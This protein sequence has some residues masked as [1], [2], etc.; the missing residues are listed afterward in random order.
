MGSGETG[1]QGDK[2]TRGASAVRRRPPL[3]R[4]AWTRGSR[5]Q[6]GEIFLFSYPF[7]FTLYPFP[8][9]KLPNT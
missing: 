8:L 1:R 3:R 7:P 6:G 2:E 9:L 5:G 4:L